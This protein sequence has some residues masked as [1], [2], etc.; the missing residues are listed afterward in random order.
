MSIS[1]FITFPLT[2]ALAVLS[3]CAY[4]SVYLQASLFIDLIFSYLFLATGYD[5]H[6][7]VNSPCHNIAVS[8]EDCCFKATIQTFRSLPLERSMNQ[9]SPCEYHKKTARAKRNMT[10]RIT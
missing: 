5:F 10:P 6:K 8:F 9:T 2:N 3:P 7:H 4:I 1:Y